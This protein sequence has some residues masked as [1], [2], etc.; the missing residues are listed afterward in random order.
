MPGCYRGGRRHYRSDIGREAMAECE[1]QVDDAASGLAGQ[2]VEE[3]ID[4]YIAV[5]ATGTHADNELM[6][7]DLICVAHANLN[8]ANFAENGT[9]RLA[10]FQW[11]IIH[12]RHGLV[13]VD[14]DIL[15]KYGPVPAD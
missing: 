1:T 14:H 4:L 6:V 15:H 10:W 3:V 9:V 5:T 12:R 13:L 2:D 7:Q 8:A 11:S